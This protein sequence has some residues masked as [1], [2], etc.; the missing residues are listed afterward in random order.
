M[1]YKEYSQASIDKLDKHLQSSFKFHTFKLWG[2]SI[3]L[4]FTEFYR[5]PS[6]REIHNILE[7]S[8]RE[9][10]NLNVHGSSFMTHIILGILIDQYGMNYYESIMYT[11]RQPSSLNS[12]MIKMLA[13]LG[14]MEPTPLKPL[15]Y[16]RSI[17]LGGLRSWTSIKPRGVSIL[18]SRRAKFMSEF[19]GPKSTKNLSSNSL[20]CYI[21]IGQRG[22][23]FILKL[24]TDRID[25]R[26]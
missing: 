10:H 4:N 18:V 19:L 26:C 2:K 24:M 6:L 11:E 13:S 15:D 8:L 1:S 7:I 17:V 9:V 16:H 22:K 3:F 14:I 20:S 23:T 5:I 12:S 25:D 21:C